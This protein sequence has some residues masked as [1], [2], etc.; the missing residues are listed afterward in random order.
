MLEPGYVGRVGKADDFHGE[1]RP[2]VDGSQLPAQ[3]Q[4]AEL[5]RDTWAVCAMEVRVASGLQGDLRE[6]AFLQVTCNI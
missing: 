6:A 3:E 1:N 4:N 5:K 2:A